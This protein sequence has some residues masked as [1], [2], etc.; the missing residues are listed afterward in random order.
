[1]QAR[2]LTLQDPETFRD[3]YE[4]THIII[5]RFI[6]G[7]HGGPI[8]EVEDLTCDTYFRAWKGR[9]QFSG[10]N[11]D[12]LCWLFTIARHLVI[13]EHRR[14]RTHPEGSMLRI[15]DDN[16]REIW[17]STQ[18]TPEEQTAMREQ[19]KYLWQALQKL[20]EEKREILVL[21]YMVGWKVKQI[22]KYIHKEENTVSVTIRRVLAQIRQN[23]PTDRV[24][25]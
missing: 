15:D 14:R 16:F 21:R 13:D 25:L 2:N 17:I 18:K 24:D 20:P 11:H 23:W 9:N 8:E 10:D 5:F 7:L 19:F 1:M 4:N 3:L 22:A 12:A 6:Y